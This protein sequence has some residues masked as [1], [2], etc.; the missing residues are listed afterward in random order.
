MRNQI[1]ALMAKLSP[2]DRIAIRCLSD[3][4]CLG[5]PV[6]QEELAYIVTVLEKLTTSVR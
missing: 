1:E 5:E 3:Y 6:N 4:Y 2:I